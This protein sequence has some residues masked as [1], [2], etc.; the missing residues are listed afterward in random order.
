MHESSGDTCL[1]VGYE[2]VLGLLQQPGEGGVEV[3]GQQLLLRGG[4]L[5]ELQ[6]W[7]VELLISRRLHLIQQQT[8]Q[9]GG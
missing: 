2:E 3:D 5:M 7:L 4:L 8:K 6:E 1:N 9:T